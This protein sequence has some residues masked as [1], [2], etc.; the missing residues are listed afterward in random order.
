MDSLAVAQVS[1]PVKLSMEALLS[2]M[3]TVPTV[4]E[5]LTLMESQPHV[6]RFMPTVLVPNSVTAFPR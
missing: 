1:R 2:T 3:S 6:V 5:N 4:C